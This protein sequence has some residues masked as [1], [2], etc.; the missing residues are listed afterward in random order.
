MFGLSVRCI[1]EAL[2]NWLSDAVHFG[3][4]MICHFVYESSILIHYFPND[5]KAGNTSPGFHL[6]IKLT[7]FISYFI[8]VHRR[9]VYSIEWLGH[10]FLDS[11]CSHKIIN[12]FIQ[13][14]ML[15]YVLVSH[16]NKCNERIICNLFNYPNLTFSRQFCHIRRDKESVHWVQTPRFRNTCFN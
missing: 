13:I 11:K 1:I 2:L 15:Q 10:V 16:V 6:Y 12:R 9:S 5:V 8:V 14:F 3:S 7:P 4:T